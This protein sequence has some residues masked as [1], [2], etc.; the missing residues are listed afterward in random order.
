VKVGGAA[1]LAGSL[2]LRFVKGFRPQSGS[3]ITLL[4][5]KSLSGK[6]SN[7]RDQFR[8]A[9]NRFQIGY[10]ATSVILTVL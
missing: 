4:K 2:D 5:A 9:G 7:K 1:R 8:A 3:K 10:T 6:F